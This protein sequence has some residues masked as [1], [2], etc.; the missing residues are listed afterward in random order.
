MVYDGLSIRGVSGVHISVVMFKKGRIC[1]LGGSLSSILYIP[2]YSNNSCKST[3]LSFRTI[4][5][6]LCVTVRDC[7]HRSV[8]CGK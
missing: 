2:T 5:Q 1:G 8:C 7:F 4:F 3:I 6:M